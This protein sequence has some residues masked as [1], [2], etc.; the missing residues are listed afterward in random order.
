MG[1]SSH[2]AGWGSLMLPLLL[3]VLFDRFLVE[4]RLFWNHALT[5]FTSLQPMKQRVHQTPIA[6]KHQQNRGGTDMCSRSASEVRS[7]SGGCS[8]LS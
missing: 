7:S 3:A 2:C 4:A 6:T 8:S 5:V 1:G